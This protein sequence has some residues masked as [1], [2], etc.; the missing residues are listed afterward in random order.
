MLLFYFRRQRCVVVASLDPA[1]KYFM[2][3]TTT[4]ARLM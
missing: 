3:V 4:Q 2:A 1:V